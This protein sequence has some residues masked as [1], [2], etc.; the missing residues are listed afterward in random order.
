MSDLTQ[1]VLGLLPDSYPWPDLFQYFPEVSSTNDMLKVLA[2]QGAPQGTALMAGAQSAG[3]GRLGRNF[4]SPPHTGVYLSMLLRPRCAPAQL[5]HL[6][7]ATAVAMCDAVEQ[8]AGIRP[9]IKWTNDL[10]WQRRKLGGILTELGLS[11]D[12]WVEYAIVGIGIN[13]TTPDF[14]PELRSMTTSLEQI[15]HRQ[16][17]RQVLAAAMLTHLANMGLDLVAQREVL[18]H[19]Y[20]RD[21]ITIGQDIS[22]VQGDWVRHG[23]AVDV[24]SQGALVV[25]FPDGTVEAVNAGEVSVRGMYGYV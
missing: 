18:L 3:R 13:C 9:G 21:C 7:C 19:Q 2:K 20:R 15:T 6:T 16:I 25:R 1:C 4:Q 5:M 22:L 11:P 8:T 17:P 14:G 23:R 24:D 10:V 12:G